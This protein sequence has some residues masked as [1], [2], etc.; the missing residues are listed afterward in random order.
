MSFCNLSTLGTHFSDEPKKS[1][2]FLYYSNPYLT[3]LL[4]PLIEQMQTSSHRSRELTS[5]LKEMFLK[6]RSHAFTLGLFQKVCPV[7]KP[8]TELTQKLILICMTIDPGT[9]FKNWIAFHLNS[10]KI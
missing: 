6:Q 5:R 3:I 1:K 7:I 4:V 8:L 10:S 9:D 2:E